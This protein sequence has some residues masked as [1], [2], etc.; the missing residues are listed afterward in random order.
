MKTSTIALDP[1]LSLKILAFIWH[2]T[3]HKTAHFNHRSGGTTRAVLLS[4]NKS[5]NSTPHCTWES[6]NQNWSVDFWQS[7]LH[8]TVSKHLILL[9][10]LNL[11]LTL[12]LEVLEKKP[13]LRFM[14]V[15]TPKLSS[16]VLI[17]IHKM[18]KNWSSMALWLQELMQF[19]FSCEQ[20]FQKL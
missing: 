18:W 17:A 19:T 14:V 4:I 9:H 16:N 13:Q 12:T 15:L 10:P 1:Y 6:N 3:W 2:K 7:K 5:C 8:F 11:T 20:E